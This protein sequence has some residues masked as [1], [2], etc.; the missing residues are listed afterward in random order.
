MSF[1]LVTMQLSDY[2]T[3]AASFEELSIKCTN[4]DVIAKGNETT[5]V[6]ASQFSLSTIVSNLVGKCEVE[7]RW[8]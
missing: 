5:V 1:K 2:F 4:I 3:N 8:S 7:C 6:A